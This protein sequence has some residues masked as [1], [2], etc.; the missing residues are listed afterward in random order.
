MARQQKKAKKTAPTAAPEKHLK[1][2]LFSN[3]NSGGLPENIIN[4]INNDN[5]IN[6]LLISDTAT[7][8]S[9]E[10]LKSVTSDSLLSELTNIKPDSQLLFIDLSSID[11]ELNLNQLINLVNKEETKI[12]FTL[13]LLRNYALAMLLEMQF[14][15]FQ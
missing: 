9:S 6:Y 12:I 13:I 11:G 7:N 14:T 8:T 10:N 3:T 2:V 15:Y 5:S 1:F 4:Q